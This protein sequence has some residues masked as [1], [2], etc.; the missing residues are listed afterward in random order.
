MRK[1]LLTGILALILPLCTILVRSGSAQSHPRDVYRPIPAGS[2]FPADAARLQHDLDTEQLHELRRHA[3]RVF[4]GLTKR[5]DV[6]EDGV[7]VPVWETWFSVND[8]FGMDS[9]SER[10]NIRRFLEPPEELTSSG[11]RP[12]SGKVI[13]LATEILYNKP[14]RDYI[15]DNCLYLRQKLK[16]FLDNNKLDPLDFPK[17]SIVLKTSWILVKKDLCLPLGVWDR[18]RKFPGRLQNDRFSWARLNVSVPPHTC[19]MLDRPSARVTDFHRFKVPSDPQVLDALHKVDGFE[20]AQA[21]DFAILIGFHFATRELPNWVWAT[22]WWHDKPNQGPY[23]EDR[24]SR[25]PPP[26]RNY[27]MNVSYDMDLPAEPDARPHVA[28]NP[29]L[30]GSLFDGVESNCMTCHRRATWPLDG[31]RA[32]EVLNSDGSTTSPSLPGIVVRGSQAATGTYF[33]MPFDHLLKTSFLWSLVLHSTGDASD[34]PAC[35]CQ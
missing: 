22:F 28:Y 25:L 24:P 5:S 26:W 17:E 32:I 4:A 20:S 34:L 19:P 8:T 27:L 10:I 12:S 13:D 31:N 16:C 6:K 29:Y 23:A 18:K 35:K 2:D 1:Y 9:A 33:N 14:A 15:R 3:W 30:E 21:G 7:T 11:Q